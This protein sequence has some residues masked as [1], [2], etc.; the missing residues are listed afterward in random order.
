MSR[1]AVSSNSGV[2]SPLNG[3]FTSGF[4]LLA[5]YKLTGALYWIP[6]ATLAAIIVT[7]VYHLFGPLS[8]F[9]QFWRTSLA[10]FIA[11]MICFWVTIFVS[12]E[13]GI[14]FAVVFSVAYTLVR[15]AF[16]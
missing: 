6:K 11:S 7:A 5:I 13:E 10:D 16:S 1:T 8:V 4:V 9:Y 14:L 3:I 15:A 2:K 12:A